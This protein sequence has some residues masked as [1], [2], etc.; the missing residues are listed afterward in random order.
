MLDG[1]E[2]FVEV[3]SAGSFSGAAR[4][5]GMPTTTVSA[6]IARLEA[7]LGITLI[8]RT[9]RRLHVTPAGQAYYERCARALAEVAEGERELTETVQEVAGV[10]RLT[11]PSDLAATALVPVVAAYLAA[12]PRARVQLIV[13]NAKLDLLAEGID[14]AIRASRGL[15]DSSLV[16]RRWMM[17]RLKIWA[18]PA[19]VARR[20]VPGT[21]AEVAQHDWVGLSVLPERLELWGPDGVPVEISPSARLACDDMNTVRACVAQG[22]GIGLL[23]DFVTGEAL[24]Q[25]LPAYATPPAPV[26]LVY[27]AQRFVPRPVR[28]F[29]DLV[30]GGG[31]A[32]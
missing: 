32:A 26:F 30:T 27:P 9:T 31:D 22:L 20:G 28:A 8:Q 15:P 3:V 19:Y 18:S 16:V 14:L 4:R 24:V 13:T 7:R 1:I 17:G 23:P 21:P 10:L 12:H 6:R 5:L 29:I 25:V 11:A 2:V